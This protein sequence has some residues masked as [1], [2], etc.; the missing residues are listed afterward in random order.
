MQGDSQLSG[1]LRVKCLAQGHIDTRRSRGS[2]QHQQV[3]EEAKVFLAAMG[4]SRQP[5]SMLFVASLIRSRSVDGKA[6][7]FLFLPDMLK[8][9]FTI[10]LKHGH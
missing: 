10:R 6:P 5:L 4:K 3:H 8:I 7:F 9:S 2:N 1:A